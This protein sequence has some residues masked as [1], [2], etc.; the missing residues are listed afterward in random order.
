MLFNTLLPLND[1]LPNNTPVD[2]VIVVVIL[3]F[4]IG[5]ELFN[6]KDKE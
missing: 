4:L 5:A 3:L 2:W 6:Y 1:K